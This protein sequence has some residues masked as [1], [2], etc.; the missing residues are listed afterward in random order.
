MAWLV[1]RPPAEKN[2]YTRASMWREYPPPLYSTSGFVQ[3]HT[4]YFFCVAEPPASSS[5]HGHPLPLSKACPE[6]TV[7]L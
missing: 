4:A 3:A 7:F 5:S 1:C 2:C 6:G